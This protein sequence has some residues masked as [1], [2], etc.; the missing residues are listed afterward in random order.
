MMIRS[1]VPL[2]IFVAVATGCGMSK[3]EHDRLLQEALAGQNAAFDA[4]M[5]KAQQA[6]ATEVAARDN[7]IKSLEGD[8]NKLGFDM[9]Q[10][11]SEM[12]SQLASTQSQLDQL[13]KRQEAAER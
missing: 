6:H 4:E 11:Q 8:L 9:K 13:R 7:R 3:K 10:T 2:S 1:L 12:G 5:K